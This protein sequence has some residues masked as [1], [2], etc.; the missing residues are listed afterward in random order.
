VL[1]RSSRLVYATH[2]INQNPYT[3]Q[4]KVGYF[5]ASTGAASALVAAAQYPG[6][7]ESIVSRGGRPDLAGEALG[8]VKAPVLLL[9]GGADPQ[10]IDS[11]NRNNVGFC[12]KIQQESRRYSSTQGTEE[13]LL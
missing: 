12:L 10:V 3:R 7:V 6:I 8:R 13:I 9:V 11:N 2:F 1:F 5:G 4:L